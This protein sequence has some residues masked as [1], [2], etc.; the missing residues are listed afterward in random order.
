MSR[1][2]HSNRSGM[3][4]SPVS[5]KGTQL[6]SSQLLLCSAVL[7]QVVEPEQRRTVRQKRFNGY[8]DNFR[9]GQAVDSSLLAIT[10]ERSQ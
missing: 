3:H 5:C 8:G 7:C 9:C 6:F 4:F 10:Q 1:R 2:A